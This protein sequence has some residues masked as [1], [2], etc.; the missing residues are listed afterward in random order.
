[1]ELAKE[2]RLCLGFSQAPMQKVVGV[3]AAGE[4]AEVE[5]VVFLEKKEK[6]DK[7]CHRPPCIDEQIFLVLR[8]GKIAHAHVLGDFLK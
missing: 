4:E 1:M 6:L 8:M 2:Q 7:A 5:V 3:Q